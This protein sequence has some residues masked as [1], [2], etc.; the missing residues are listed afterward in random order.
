MLSVETLKDIKV[1]YHL[2]FFKSVTNKTDINRL[3]CCYEKNITS[4]PL[5]GRPSFSSPTL[6]DVSE[7][8]NSDTSIQSSKSRRSRSLLC[9]KSLCIICQQTGGELHKVAYTVTGCNMYKVAQQLSDQ[10]LFISLNSIPDPTDAVAN[11]VVYHLTCWVKIK[12][13]ALKSSSANENTIPEIDNMDTVLADIEIISVVR[14][15][16]SDAEKKTFLDMND[17]NTT[18]NNLLRNSVEKHFNHNRYLKLC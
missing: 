4:T 5:R 11:D 2:F 10:S 15:S 6:D 18:Y 12:R 1:F 3:E 16:L 7:C 9:D 8:D 13:E 14:C 17:T